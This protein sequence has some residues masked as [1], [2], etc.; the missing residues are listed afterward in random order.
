MIN[1]TGNGVLFVFSWWHGVCIYLMMVMER[2][3][4]ILA[5]LEFFDR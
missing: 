1:G 5:T 2:V 4:L 3:D